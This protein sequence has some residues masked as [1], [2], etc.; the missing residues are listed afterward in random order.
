MNDKKNSIK[1]A[2]TQTVKH[3]DLTCLADGQVFPASF[4]ETGIN[5]NELIIGPT[6]SGKTYSISIPRIV[7][8]YHKSLVV[9]IAK[10]AVREKCGKLLEERGYKVINLDYAH[11]EACS[12]GYDPMDYIHTAADVVQTAKNL[13][14][15]NESKTMTGGI[16][17]YWNDSA[18]SILAAFI[19]FVRIK[20]EHSGGRPSF[21]EVIEIYRNMKVDDTNGHFKSSMDNT[22]EQ[23][24]ELYP[25]NQ[26]TELWKTIKGLASKTA[27]CI[28]SIV[29]NALDKIFSDNIIAMMGKEERISFADL[30]KERIALF[31]TTSP[32]NLTLQNFINLMYADMFR[33][34]FETAEKSEE[35]CLD[36]PVH[37]VCDDFAC[38][39]KIACFEDYISIFRAA[40]ISVTLLLQSESQLSGMYGQMAAT[41]IINNC[42]T[43]VYMGGRDVETCRSISCR[44]NKPLNVIMDMPLEQVMVFRRGSSP[45]VSRRY[46]IFD[47]PLYIRMEKAA[48]EAT[49]PST[50]RA[51]KKAANAEKDTEIKDR[52]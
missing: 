24:G 50:R 48:K 3:K 28:L 6:G 52:D 39:S 44:M 21:V 14:G 16:D 8:T 20:A 31:I 45:V 37:I 1:K 2:G 29:N 25:G 38:G 7:H 47:D 34:L 42:D 11:P 32:V 18:A 36:V 30:G 4:E 27:S 13:I 43:Y 12:I 10:K 41:T 33:T 40:G 35:G 19:A 9:P 23:L 5:C 49:K 46:Q 22:F 15:L 51:T 17:P 26:A